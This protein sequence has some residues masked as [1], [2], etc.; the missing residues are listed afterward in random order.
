MRD[1]A[2]EAASILTPGAR[3]DGT[4]PICGVFP[5]DGN[6]G[7]KYLFTQT[8]SSFLTARQYPKTTLLRWSPGREF[9]H[10]DDA[11]RAKALKEAKLRPAASA[12]RHEGRAREGSGIDGVGSGMIGPPVRK[13]R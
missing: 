3:R 8:P 6:P 4:W 10:V 11:R 2:L 5:A 7:G 13:N 1:G 9:S 12:L